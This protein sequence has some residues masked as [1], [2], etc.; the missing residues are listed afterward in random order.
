MTNMDCRT[1]WKGGIQ[2]DRPGCH[3]LERKDRSDPPGQSHRHTEGLTMSVWK[4][5]VLPGVGATAAFLEPKMALM[6]DDL[7]TLG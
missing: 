5:L 6:V 1:C 4:C 3:M 2:F 7:P